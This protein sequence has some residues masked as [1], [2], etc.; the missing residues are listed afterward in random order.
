MPPIKVPKI[1]I[2]IPK[3]SITMALSQSMGIPLNTINRTSKARIKAIIGPQI[4]K[5]F[6]TAV[7]NKD[8]TEHK[9]EP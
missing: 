3:I 5:K 2:S 8:K 1:I 7:P 6:K 4:G 9:R